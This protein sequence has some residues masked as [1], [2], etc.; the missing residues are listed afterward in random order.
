MF[1]NGEE[2]IRKLDTHTY[3]QTRYTHIQII[4]IHTNYKHTCK[5]DTHVHTHIRFQ[6]IL[7][8]QTHTN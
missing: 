8:A 5:L 6:Y 1:R 4:C 3:T 7:D 2:R